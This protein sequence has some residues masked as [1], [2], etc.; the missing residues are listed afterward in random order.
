MTET[1]DFSLLIDA[2]TRIHD[3]RGMI[4][5]HLGVEMRQLP[6]R[7]F[8]DF[9]DPANRSAFRRR[10]VKM[11]SG[12]LSGAVRVRVLTCADEPEE[13][14]ATLKQS[15]AEGQWWL[16]LVRAI[17][18]QAQAPLAE[19]ERAGLV[20]GEDFMMLVESAARQL[21][22]ELDLMKIRASLLTEEASGSGTTSPAVRE[23]LESEFNEIVVESAYD[24]IAT[25]PQP[26]EYLMLMDRTKPAEEILGKLGAAAGRMSVP[27]T[28][29]GLA[30]RT[31][32][33]ESLEGDFSQANINGVVYDL[34]RDRG[35]PLTEWEPEP[36]P[37]SWLKPMIRS[38]AAALSGILPSTTPRSPKKDR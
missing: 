31:V 9:V 7:L 23:R 6:G 3:A 25:R 11:I 27:P 20:E 36:Q 16:L 37:R 26:G 15:P 29:L 21:N 19:S 17:R 8:I 24:N 5:Q 18:D 10:L 14:F 1:W 38:A 35:K 4:G 34:R 22:G 28:D 32:P 2:S 33:M 12:T 30:S 13:F